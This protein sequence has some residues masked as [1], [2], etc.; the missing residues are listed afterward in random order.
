MKLRCERDSLVEALALAGRASSGRP[1]AGSTPAGTRLSLS[2]ERLEVTGTDQDLTISTEVPVSG[3]G[4]GMVVAPGRLLTDIVRSLE[5]GAVTLEGDEDELQVS[6]GR[7]QFTLRVFRAADF[8]QMPTP[9]GVRVSLPTAGLAE[10]LRQV[11]RAASSEV[12]R[13]VLTGVLMTA[14]A[15]GLRMVATDSY[16]LAVKDLPEARGVFEEG[17]KVLV[18]SRALAELQRLLSADTGAVEVYLSAHEV[19]FDVGQVHLTAR[20]IEGDFPPYRQ[21]IPLSYPNKLRVAR[22]P[23]L[24][25]VRRVRLVARDSARPS[26]AP[27]PVRILLKADTAQL[28]VVTPDSGQ[29]V[30]EVDA[31]YEGEEMTIAFNP[32]YLAEGVEAVPG[33]DVLIETQ[34]PGKP[35]T[36]KPAERGDYV[37]LLMP[38]RVA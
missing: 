4:D 33:E 14:E 25:A 9:P 30:E 6:S 24:D 15:G 29:A 17:Q 20:L 36:I 19:R 18:P 37:Y 8:P 21:L 34:D 2:G 26:D 5:P 1:S 10:A 22:E 38:V 11:V 13:P 27:T 32:Q 35:A 3:G 7:S 12:H 31:K 28:S 23:F 16:R